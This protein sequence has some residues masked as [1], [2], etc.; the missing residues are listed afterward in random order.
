MEE[1]ITKIDIKRIKKALFYEILGFLH[2]GFVSN[3]L[4]KVKNKKFFTFYQQMRKNLKKYYE[5]DSLRYFIEGEEQINKL[6]KE[7]NVLS[8]LK[9]NN[10]LVTLEGMKIIAKSYAWVYDLNISSN[11]L[12]DNGLKNLVETLIWTSLT[13]LNNY[14]VKQY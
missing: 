11:S 12:G 10:C 7:I 5:N 6:S 4:V 13:R 2:I 3:T 14:L 9:I 8:V 1:S